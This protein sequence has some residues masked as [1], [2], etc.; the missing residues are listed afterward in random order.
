MSATRPVVMMLLALATCA[1]QRSPQPAPAAPIGN[2]ASA[3]LRHDWLLPASPGAA[4]PNLVA[5][6]D[7]RLLLSWISSV[8]GRRNA[9]QFTQYASDGSRQ[10]APVTIAIGDSLVANWANIPHIVATADGALWV[11]W[12]QKSGGSGDATDVMLSRSRDGGFN[13]NPPA[14]VNSGGKPAEHGF[15]ALWPATRD[16]VGIAWL[17]GRNTAPEANAGDNTPIG[18]MILRA[19]LF[20]GAMRRSAEAELDAMT[21]DCCQVD[22]ALTARGALLAYRDRSPDE[23][24]DIATTRFDGATWSKPKPVH[25]DNW[26]MTACPV[27]GPA[28]AASGNDVVVAWYTAAGDVPMVRIAR[29][30]DAGDTFAAPVTLDQGEAVRGR[31]DVAVDK[32]Q[33]WV[34]WIREDAAGQSL[35]L[36]RYTP[37]LSR[38]LQRVEVARLQGRGNATGFPQLALHNGA[39]YLVWTDIVDGA[40]QLRGA[41]FSSN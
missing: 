13:W 35:W 27:N 9:L 36:A 20:D 33:A 2:P 30:A 38:Q 25:V 3:Y 21:C 14:A 12:L 7:G 39:A 40:P 41:L 37:D 8:P 11:H 22:V 1:C 10:S 5:T 15:A 28:V 32:A 26:K 16:S 34:T 23:I 4:Q 31:V 19:A 6:A 24:R 17:D 29:S 18:A